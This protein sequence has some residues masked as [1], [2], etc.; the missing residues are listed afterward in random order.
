M[1]KKRK[2]FTKS[3]TAILEKEYEKCHYPSIEEKQ[4]ISK[5]HGLD[6]IKVNNWFY[7]KRR[8]IKKSSGTEP[9]PSTILQCDE[10]F[11]K[12]LSELEKQANN[13]DETNLTSW[14]K[15]SLFSDDETMS[16]GQHTKIGSSESDQI[17]CLFGQQYVMPHFISKAQY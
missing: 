8:K 2:R 3:E 7:N 4:R 11:D 16:P 15:Q 10:Y 5:E 14:H 12:Q 13:R 17:T 6:E 1:E 9:G